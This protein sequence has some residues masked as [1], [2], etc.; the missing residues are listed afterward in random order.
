MFYLVYYMDLKF[1]HKSSDIE[2]LDRFHRD[3]LRQFQSLPKRTAIPSVYLLLGAMSV[4][5]ELHKRQLSFFYLLLSAENNKLN[6]IVERLLCVN[7]DNKDSIIEVLSLY[8]LPS[9]FELQ[10]NLP[11]KLEWKKWSCHHL[12]L[13]GLKN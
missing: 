6:N 8:N 11:T 1:Y 9:I 13:S 12:Y 3:T 10:Q 4:E 5:G 7:F 2:K